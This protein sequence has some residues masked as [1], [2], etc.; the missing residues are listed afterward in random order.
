M[1]GLRPITRER[2]EGSS[3]KGDKMRNTLIIAGI[4]AFASMPGYADLGIEDTASETAAKTEASGIGVSTIY[5]HP[6]D[7][8][9]G[10]Y[11]VP[12]VY[13]RT[14]V[15][16]NGTETQAGDAKP[17]DVDYISL[18]QL[19]GATGAVGVAGTQGPKGD[20]GDPGKNLEAPAIDPRLDVE[21][22]EYDSQHWTMSSFASFGMQS[23]T[24]Q[25]I[26]G[27][28]LTLK[29]GKSYE[30]KERELLE[31]RIQ[32]TLKDSILLGE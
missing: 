8:S 17:N 3:L 23:T 15:E 6:G 22:R 4:L 25:Y 31:G 19:K 14:A 13:N 29:L 7:V 24:A 16:G 21:V 2:T 20:K 27:Q 28:R 18:T 10:S 5:D 11:V 30:E 1:R 9:N 12:V 26:V 32:K